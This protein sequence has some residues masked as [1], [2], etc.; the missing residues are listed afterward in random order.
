MQIRGNEV[1]SFAYDKE[2]L[3]GKLAL[4]LDPDLGLY[5]GPQ[6]I[7]EVK[8][9]FGL[10]TDS[11]PDRWGRVLMERR[12]AI[13]AR[14]EDQKP[15]KLTESDYLLGVYDVYRM[16][17]LRFKLD[18][19]GPFLDN[20]QDMPTPPFSS[21]RSLEE[22]SLQLEKKDAEKNPAFKKWLRLLLLPGASLGGARPKASITGPNGKLWIAKFPSRGDQW[23]TGA[24]EWVVNRLAAK[25]GVNTAKAM[26]KKLTQEWHTFLT[27]RFDRENSLNSRHIHFAS[28]MTLLGYTDG[29]DATMGVS[30]LQIAE[31]ILRQGAAPD[32]DLEEFWRRI[33]F[34]KAVS[35]TDDHL[36]NHGFL[37]NSNGWLLSPAYDM[38]PIP[39]SG[40]LTLNISEFSNTLDLDIAREV[41]AKFRVSLN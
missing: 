4:L 16:G 15:K 27:E 23:D 28:A 19:A 37:L 31:F 13:R 9:N 10:F 14:E 36:R 41:S 24:W 2:W 18:K 17:G 21:I 40:G 5:P 20:N 29:A 11:S 22:A 12:E 1:F 35:N 30:Y 32:K 7:R 26:A 38:N 8:P 39:D 33:V 25:A 34:N 6:Y 3:T